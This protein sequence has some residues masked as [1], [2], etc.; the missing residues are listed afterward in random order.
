MNINQY[1]NILSALYLTLVQKDLAL[2]RSGGG[3]VDSTQVY[4]RCA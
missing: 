3:L 1:H 2:S 4:G